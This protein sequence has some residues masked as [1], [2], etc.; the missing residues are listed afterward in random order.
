MHAICLHTVLLPESVWSVG[1]ISWSSLATFLWFVMPGNMIYI[2]TTNHTHLNRHFHVKLEIYCKRG[3]AS[4]PW[5]GPSPHFYK[6]NQ[7]MYI[8]YFIHEYFIFDKVL[9][10]LL[11]IFMSC[12][13][14]IRVWKTHEPANQVH[15]TKIIIFGTIFN[16]RILV[17]QFF[18]EFFRWV[19]S[20]L[21]DSFKATLWEQ[22]YPS[23]FI[24]I[25]K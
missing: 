7:S 4:F 1:H 18:T 14:L 20:T 21:T 24:K 22:S 12:F 10:C 25:I 5:P 15:G 23:W 13:L 16:L 17:L 2:V 9:K 3:Q 19:G 11:V 6:P 8:I